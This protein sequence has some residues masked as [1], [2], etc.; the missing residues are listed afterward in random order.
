MNWLNCPE[1]L[2]KKTKEAFQGQDHFI[3]YG[4]TSGDRGW[5]GEGDLEVSASGCV[6]CWQVFLCR[7]RCSQGFFKDLE[8]KDMR[9]LLRVK[10]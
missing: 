1:D 10:L 5:E 9:L 7:G 2:G 8:I 4:S 3:A 6:G